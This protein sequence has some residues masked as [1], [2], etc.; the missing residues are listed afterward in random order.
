MKIDLELKIGGTFLRFKFSKWGK[1]SLTKPLTAA[2]RACT[3]ALMTTVGD[4]A[5]LCDSLDIAALSSH[6]AG[7]LIET[8][9]RKNYVKKDFRQT[10]C[11]TEEDTAGR[12]TRRILSILEKM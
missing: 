11:F 7:M 2:W 3:I 4:D 5:V 10:A 6:I 9:T 8:N 12:I 1:S